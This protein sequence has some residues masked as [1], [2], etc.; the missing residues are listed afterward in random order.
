MKKWRKNKIKTHEIFT[1]Q[2][3]HDHEIE[4]H[5]KQFND[6]HKA[7]PMLSDL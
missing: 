3:L 1:T 2:L 6:L 7:Q 5:E 4:L